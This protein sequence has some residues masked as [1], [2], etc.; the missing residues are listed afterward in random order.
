MNTGRVRTAFAPTT[1]LLGCTT[2]PV[3]LAD[4][5]TCRQNVFGIDSKVKP[6]IVFILTAMTIS[7]SEQLPA[8][9]PRPL[10]NCANLSRAAD[11]DTG[12]RVATSCKS[13]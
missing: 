11:L 7:S 9:S 4:H 13:L 12:K 1:A 10:M 8:R 5:S 6:K 3:V 2:K